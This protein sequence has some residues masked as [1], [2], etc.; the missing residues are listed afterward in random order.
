MTSDLRRRARRGP[1]P[2]GLEPP[3]GPGGAFAGP[4]SWRTRLPGEAREAAPPDRGPRSPPGGRMPPRTPR[5]G[6]IRVPP[7]ARG[8]PWGGPRGAPV[9]PTGVPKSHISLTPPEIGLLYWKWE[10][11]RWHAREKIKNRDVFAKDRA[12]PE[13]ASNSSVWVGMEAHLRGRRR[14]IRIRGRNPAPTGSAE[15]AQPPSP[16]LAHVLV[17]RAKLKRIDAPGVCCR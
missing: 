2:P 13:M 4:P 16:K 10:L 5:G 9:V 12:S 14:G 7:G 17:P 3:R 1:G 15:A 6:G 11:G 8:D